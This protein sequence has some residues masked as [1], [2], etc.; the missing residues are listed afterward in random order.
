MSTIYNPLT[1]IN[2]SDT[3]SASR[4]TLNTN[5]TL[6]HAMNLREIAD[7]DHPYTW[8]LGDDCI[9]VTSTA[10]PITINLPAAASHK[11]KTLQVVLALGTG[12]GVVLDGN[13]SETING[14]TT[15]TLTGTYGT[16]R[17]L[18]TGTEWIIVAVHP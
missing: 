13:A 16:A 7:A 3:I 8:Q 10:I 14:A 17:I 4:S 9:V 6:R 11:G 5:F 18:C 15:Q 12:G 2:S 1:T